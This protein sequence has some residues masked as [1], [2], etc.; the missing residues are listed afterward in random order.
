MEI[1][2]KSWAQMIPNCL[3]WREMAKKNRRQMAVPPTF[4]H[5]S[6]WRHSII[7][8]LDHYHLKSV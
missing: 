5:Y 6:V 2:K 8:I 4:Y 7:I 3:I 1:K